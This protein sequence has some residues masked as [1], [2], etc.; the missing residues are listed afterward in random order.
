MTARLAAYQR[1]HSARDLRVR[2][3][4]PEVAAAIDHKVS[5]RR[6]VSVSL[7]VLVGRSAGASSRDLVGA[8]GR[9]WTVGQPAG[10]WGPVAARADV[11]PLVV[12]AG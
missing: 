3:A 6:T 2:G 12:T 8:D 11:V 5:P 4:R 1:G 7:V 10:P 9:W